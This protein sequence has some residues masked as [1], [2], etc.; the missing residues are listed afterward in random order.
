MLRRNYSRLKKIQNKRNIKNAFIF[1]F[2][3]FAM[4]AFFIFIGIPLLIKYTSFISDIRKSSEPIEK[5]DDTPPPPPRIDTIPES[6]NELEIKIGGKSEPGATLKIFYNSDK[7]E[8]LANNEGYFS[9]DINLAEGNNT[10]TFQAMDKSGNE[11]Q[12]T[13]SF[14]IVYD[15]EP[16]ELTI[17]SPENNITLYGSNHRQLTIAGVSEKNTRVYINERI[18]VVDDEGIFS[19]TTSLTEG[20]N[21]FNIVAEDE[22]GNKTE[23]SLTVNY[24][25]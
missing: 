24:I 8:V 10:I 21:S 6:T 4:L 5:N 25:P 23:Q 9:T 15:N 19:F 17:K 13:K 16:P 18:V 12:K 22:A 14:N 20:E 1:I 3:S 7:K 11:S 2:L